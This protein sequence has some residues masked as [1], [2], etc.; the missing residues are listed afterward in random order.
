[1]L[2]GQPPHTLPSAPIPAPA[3]CQVRPDARVTVAHP[4]CPTS[5]RRLP[6]LAKVRSRRA[7]LVTRTKRYGFA[8]LQ[9]TCGQPALTW[10]MIFRNN[11]RLPRD[12]IGGCAYTRPVMRGR[13][14][15][16]E[17]NRKRRL[18]KFASNASKSSSLPP[19]FADRTQQF[20]LM[21]TGNAASPQCA[22]TISKDTPSGIQPVRWWPFY[23]FILA[24][25][26]N[27]PLAAPL[28]SRF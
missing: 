22:S 14:T 25:V 23:P 18:F 21:D 2:T 5:K 26:W 10:R 20:A 27:P 7:R 28:G 16:S 24:P 8:A 1:M 19:T 6:A 15:P 4:R 17:S 3:A 9:A 11:H 12:C 13:L